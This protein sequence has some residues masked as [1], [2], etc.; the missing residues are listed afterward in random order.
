MFNP[1][2]NQMT[3]FIGWVKNL[4]VVNFACNCKKVGTTF[5]IGPTIC[6]SSMNEGK[7]QVGWVVA[8]RWKARKC[9]K[10]N[11]ILP[12]GYFYHVLIQ[13]KWMWDD[14][15]KKLVKNIVGMAYK[16]NKMHAPISSYLRS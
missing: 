10:A 1:C 7:T 16:T 12:K 11:N 3:H 4:N 5:E 15:V 8:T 13:T 14:H 9:V 6:V 2:G